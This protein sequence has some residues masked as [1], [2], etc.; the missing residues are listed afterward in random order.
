M[1]QPEKVLV[2]ADSITVGE[3][4]GTLNLPVTQLV[5]EL[6]K[7]GI[8]A[9]INQRIDFETAQII[10]EELGLD[11]T[12]KRKEAEAKT[13]QRLHKPTDKAIDRPPI[14]AVM[15]HVDHGKTSLLDAILDTKTVAGEA[16]GITQHISAYQTVRKNRAI[17]LLDTPGHEAFAALRQHGAALTDVVIIVVAADDGVKPQ[18]I[19]AIRFARAA[20]AKIIVALNKIDKETANPEMVKAQL[21]SEHS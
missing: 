17:T 15:G 2:I 4:A 1:S 8:V 3:L 20:N 16:G 10:V 5:G 6:F 7:N 9:T 11:V 14:V 13:V 21:A 12:L 19:E 18:T